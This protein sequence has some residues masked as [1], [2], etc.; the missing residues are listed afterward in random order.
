MRI[1]FRRSLHGFHDLVHAALVLWQFYRVKYEDH[2]A[3]F[4]LITAGLSGL[5]A[6]RD[7]Q[8]FL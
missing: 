2:Y 6:I 3:H 5:F 4:D 1:T 7:G 8:D